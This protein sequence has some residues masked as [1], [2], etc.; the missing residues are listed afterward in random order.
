[1][2]FTLGIVIYSIHYIMEKENNTSTLMEKYIEKIEIPYAVDDIVEGNIIATDRSS[3]YIDLPPMGTGIIYGREFLAA[4]DILRKVKIGDKVSAK[5]IELQTH[6]GYIDLSL[7]E[8][9]KL[10]IW[11]EAEKSIGTKQVYEV[12]PCDANRG[13]LIIEWNGV[14]GFLPASQLKED[15]YPKVING[16]KDAILSELKKIVGQR[17]N[18]NIITALPQEEKLIFSEYIEKNGGGEDGAQQEESKYEVGGIYT[19]VVTGVVDFGVFIKI[20]EKLEGLIHISEIDWGLVDSTSR[21]YSVGDQVTVKTI[22]IKDGKYSFSAKA[23]K[24]NPWE[25]ADKKYKVGDEVSGVIIKY[26]NEYGV[27]ASIEAGITGLVYI[28]NE[29]ED[30]SPNIEIG[31]TYEFEITAFD[32]KKNKLALTPKK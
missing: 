29:G 5:I 13:G 9:R 21:F 23:L 15:N 27:F 19:G 22:E 11:E 30:D 31:K 6:G 26:N 10:I 28:S 12:T 24:K 14:R 4:K 8:A 16:D 25:E 1:M 18:V 3:V 20:D 32:A 17:I 7:K 2:L